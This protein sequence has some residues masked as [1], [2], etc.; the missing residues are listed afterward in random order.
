[1]LF[2]CHPIFHAFERVVGNFAILLWVWTGATSFWFLC[3]AAARLTRV[4][5][6][7]LTLALFPY[8]IFR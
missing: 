2:I 6:M 3:L 4:C 7:I 5:R 8:F 1:M